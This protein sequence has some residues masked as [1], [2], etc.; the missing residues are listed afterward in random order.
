MLQITILSIIFS[1][2]LNGCSENIDKC[3]QRVASKRGG[4]NKDIGYVNIN[5]IIMNIPEYKELVEK[6]EKDKRTLADQIYQK[7]NEI[8][9]KEN[10]IREKEN[11]DKEIE[12]FKKKIKKELEQK[13]DK[14]MI[15][16]RT[17]ILKT[18]K[19]INDNIFQYKLIFDISANPN[20]IV[21][22]KTPEEVSSLTQ[23]I[24]EELNK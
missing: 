18:I 15:L 1:Y 9:E 3:N 23:K 10:E 16:I 13:Y 21:L 5:E 8:R 6:K 19:K 2:V 11:K 7:Q 4:G 24:I 14:K 17:K 12:D 20:N 22:Y